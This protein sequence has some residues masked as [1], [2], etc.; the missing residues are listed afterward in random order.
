MLCFEEA[1]NEYFKQQVSQL[2]V[3]DA[4]LFRQSSIRL[5]VHNMCLAAH[6]QCNDRCWLYYGIARNTP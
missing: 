1:G 6:H 2:R 3:N 5:Y 4:D